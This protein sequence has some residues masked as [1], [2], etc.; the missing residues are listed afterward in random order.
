VKD[1]GDGTYVVTVEYDPESGYPPAVVIGQP[2][3]DPVVV[4]PKQVLPPPKDIPPKKDVTVE[5]SWYPWLVGILLLIIV[6]LVIWHL[7]R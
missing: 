5:K 4:T 2:S 6:V 7:L 3:H 1:K